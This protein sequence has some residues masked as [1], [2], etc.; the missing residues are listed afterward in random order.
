MVGGAAKKNFEE[1]RYDLAKKKKKK[2]LDTRCVSQEK[3][4]FNVK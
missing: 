2:C 1:E 3:N 4:T